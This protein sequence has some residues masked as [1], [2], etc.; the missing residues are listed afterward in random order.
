MA[1]PMKVDS[2]RLSPTVLASSNCLKIGLSGIAEP[3]LY[4]PLF[5]R[6]RDKEI[7]CYFRYL[8]VKNRMRLPDQFVAV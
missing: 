7:A 6:F 4:L 2:T 8:T 5:F 1:N 3:P